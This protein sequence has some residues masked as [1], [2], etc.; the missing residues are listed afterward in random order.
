[1]SLLL[2]NSP[3][4]F[5]SNTNIIVNVVEDGNYT[6]TVYDISGNRIKVLANQ[7][8]S[9]GQYLYQFDGIDSNGIQLAMV[10]IS[11]NLLRKYFCF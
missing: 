3:N 10:C 6:L 11:I 1:M 2:Q 7:Y 5:T 8:L 9:A 4:P